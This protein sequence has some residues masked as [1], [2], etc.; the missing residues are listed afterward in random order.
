MNLCNCSLFF[1]FFQSHYFHHST[2]VKGCIR[3]LALL[4]AALTLM[5]VCGWRSFTSVTRWF[6]SFAARAVKKINSYKWKSPILERWD[7]VFG[8]V[9]WIWARG[10]FIDIVAD[11]WVLI[12]IEH[13]SAA[14]V[15]RRFIPHSVSVF[16]SICVLKGTVVLCSSPPLNSRCTLGYATAVHSS[17]HYFMNSCRQGVFFLLISI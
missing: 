17:H 13:S 7:A 9:G 15:Q 8:D 2:S 3:P 6:L 14:Q 5:V 12:F 16:P 11:L 4:Q 1:L 10:S